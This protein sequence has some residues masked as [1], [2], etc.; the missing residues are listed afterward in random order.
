M[1]FGECMFKII[2]IHFSIYNTVPAY[3]IGFQQIFPKWLSKLKLNNYMS[4][5]WKILYFLKLW[6]PPPLGCINYA[7]YS[8][9]LNLIPL[10]FFHV[11]SKIVKFEKDHNL[12]ERA[13]AFGWDKFDFKYLL[14]D[15][16]DN[17]ASLI[18][19]LLDGKWKWWYFVSWA[20]VGDSWQNC[21]PK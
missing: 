3:N 5:R 20:T 4:E 17:L 9:Q 8:F 21:W 16:T 7:L 15:Q 11:N 1:L 2:L 18:F 6:F 13:W 12:V 19:S 10:M 14:C